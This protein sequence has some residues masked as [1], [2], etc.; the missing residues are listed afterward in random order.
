M[1]GRER[2]RERKGEEREGEKMR[3]TSKKTKNSICTRSTTIEEL[4][5]KIRHREI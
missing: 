4:T 3:E 2:E 1:S 5:E